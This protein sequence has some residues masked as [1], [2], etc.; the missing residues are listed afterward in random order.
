ML[1]SGTVFQNVAFA[2]AELADI[3]MMYER[4]QA[5]VEVNDPFMV[6]KHTKVNTSCT[7]AGG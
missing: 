4:A 7:P 3:K 1:Q 6:E 5:L 2:Q